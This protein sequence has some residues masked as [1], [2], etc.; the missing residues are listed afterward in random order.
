MC[1]QRVETLEDE[2][3]I[4]AEEFVHPDHTQQYDRVIKIPLNPLTPTPRAAHICILAVF[5]NQPCYNV[6]YGGSEGKIRARRCN[7]SL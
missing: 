2:S 6:D 1:A 4:I 3:T 5:A 7:R